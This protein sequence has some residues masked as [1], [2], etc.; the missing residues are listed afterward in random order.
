MAIPF[1]NE[2]SKTHL[3]RKGLRNLLR[4]IVDLLLLALRVQRLGRSWHRHLVS[5]MGLLGDYPH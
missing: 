5:S 2:A 4:N 3:R 1:N